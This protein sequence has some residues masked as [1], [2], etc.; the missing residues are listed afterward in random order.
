MS[1]RL[2]IKHSRRDLDKISFRPLIFRPLHHGI[3]PT[4]DKHGGQKNPGTL[5]DM[6][7]VSNS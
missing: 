1:T 2:E 3:Y 4:L 5:D 6:S 7:H